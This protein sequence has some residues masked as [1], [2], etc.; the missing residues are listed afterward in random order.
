M[1]DL[2]DPAEYTP[3]APLRRS[4]SITQGVVDLDLIAKRYHQSRPIVFGPAI[5][6]MDDSP[7]RIRL[8]VLAKVDQARAFPGIVV[9]AIDGADFG[10]RLDDF[11]VG[12]YGRTVVRLD[13]RD[14]PE[15]YR[16]DATGALATQGR[17]ESPVVLAFT[18]LGFGQRARPR[19]LRPPVVR[20][21]PAIVPRWL[22]PAGVRRCGDPRT[23][24][25]H[26]ACPRWHRLRQPGRGLT[27]GSVRHPT[28]RRPTRSRSRSTH[29]SGRRP[30]PRRTC[31]SFGGAMRADSH[32][33]T[34]AV[35][36]GGRE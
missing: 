17:M 4:A 15:F 12:L 1:R 20:G 21:Q 28:S 2:P 5:A 24:G 6:G 30:R 19:G 26:R 25:D 11:D 22:R 34:R 7:E 18:R 13:D 3:D 27:T 31:V 35:P 36:V 14:R 33:D 29:T 32:P 9:L 8:A 16:F 23:S 10:P